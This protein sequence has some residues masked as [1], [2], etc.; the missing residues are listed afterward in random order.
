MWLRVRSVLAWRNLKVP[1]DIRTG[2]VIRLG[3]AGSG[4][5]YSGL[6]VSSR[7]SVE[8][9]PGG[10]GQG[11]DLHDVVDLGGYEYDRSAPDLAGPD[12]EWPRI[13]QAEAEIAG[14]VSR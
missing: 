9:R 2:Q 5:V 7:I 3:S 6:S 1:D 11:C 13:E 12:R 4:S 10:A 8:S 14:C